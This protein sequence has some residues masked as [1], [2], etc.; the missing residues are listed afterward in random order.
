LGGLDH[1]RYLGIRAVQDLGSSG[2][3]D[4]LASGADLQ[5]GVYGSGI[6]ILQID[7]LHG[8]GLEPD[9]RNCD[10]VASDRERR[11]FVQAA[12]AGLSGASQAGGRRLQLHNGARN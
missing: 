8:G 10:R 9:F 11:N 12:G 6:A 4:G 7:L 5:L 3:L 1:A 2:D